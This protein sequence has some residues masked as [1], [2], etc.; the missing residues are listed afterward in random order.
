MPPDG[1]DDENPGSQGGGKNYNQ[2]SI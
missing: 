2:S 1:G